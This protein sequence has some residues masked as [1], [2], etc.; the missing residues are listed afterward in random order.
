MQSFP[1]LELNRTASYWV[2]N[3]CHSTCCWHSQGAKTHCPVAPQLP[4]KKECVEQ[5]KDP[6]M[7]WVLASGGI[8]HVY[9]FKCRTLKGSSTHHF[10]IQAL[11][12]GWG[13]NKAWS[14]EAFWQSSFRLNVEHL[15]LWLY[16]WQWSYF[17]KLGKQLKKNPKN[18]TFILVHLPR[19]WGFWDGAASSYMWNRNVLL[20]VAKGWFIGIVIGVI[21]PFVSSSGI[22]CL[23]SKQ[24]INFKNP[25]EPVTCKSSEWGEVQWKLKQFI[26]GVRWGWAEC[27]DVEFGLSA[28]ELSEAAM[29]WEALGVTIP[30]PPCQRMSSTPTSRDGQALRGEQEERLVGLFGG[31]ASFSLEFPNVS[32]V[33]SSISNLYL[34]WF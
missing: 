26:S 27:R 9:N 3:S 5:Y 15:G 28:E 17:L 8:T 13:F 24:K 25:V 18:V 31:C 12:L 21:F 30:K 22:F 10:A 20:A 14:A 34:P 16:L 33:N 23:G 6:I 11:V 7:A 1:H 32:G 2:Y 29:P 19:L 4:L